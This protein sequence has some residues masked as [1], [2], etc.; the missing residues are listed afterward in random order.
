MD[1]GGASLLLSKFIQNSTA[2]RESMWTSKR[3]RA[4]GEELLKS[5]TMAKHQL[6]RSPSLHGVVK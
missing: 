4:S 2:E 3:V 1:R 6:K 5:N